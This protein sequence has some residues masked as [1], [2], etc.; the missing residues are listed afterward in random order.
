[1]YL[2][3]CN[4]DVESERI[5]RNDQNQI[6]FLSRWVYCQGFLLKEKSE[7]ICLV[8]VVFF[9]LTGRASTI[10][11]NYTWLPIRYVVC[12]TGNDQ[13]CIY[14]APTRAWK[15]NKNDKKRGTRTQSTCQKK[16]DEGHSI[17]REREFDIV[18]AASHPMPSPDRMYGWWMVI[19]CKSRVWIN[20]VCL[21]GST[22]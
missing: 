4:Q 5:R 11:S 8:V 17:E 21:F 1:M 22:V 13:R 19:T 2:V 9:T 12:W 16:R 18:P 15:Q 7:R 3:Y 20:H 14:K 6:E 10:P